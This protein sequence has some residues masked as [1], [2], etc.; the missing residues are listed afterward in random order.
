MTIK[1]EKL[2]L[3]L[4]DLKSWAISNALFLGPLVAVS[5]VQF[6]M[7]QDYGAWAEPAAIVL[8][9]L[10]KLLQKYVRANTYKVE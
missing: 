3:I 10:L 1:S 2:H 5:F 6:L 4:M 9:S 7:A 8:G